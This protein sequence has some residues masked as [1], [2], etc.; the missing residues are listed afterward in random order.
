MRPYLIRRWLTDVVL[1]LFLRPLVAFGRAIEKGLGPRPA[2]WLLSPVLLIDFLRRLPD[3]NYFQRLRSQLPSSISQPP[4]W[5]HFWDMIRTWQETLAICLLYDRLGDPAWTQRITVVGIMPNQLPEWSHRPVVLASLHSGG[6]GLLRYWLRARNIPT[7][8][9]LAYLPIIVGPLAARI[10]TAGDIRY[11]LSNIPHTISIQ[12]A[13]REAIRFLVPGRALVVALDGGKKADLP[14]LCP[15][16]GAVFHLKDGA[17]RLAQRN[18]ALLIPVFVHRLAPFRFEVHFG[19]PVPDDLLAQK[20]SQPTMQ[21][22]ATAFWD[23]LRRDPYAFNW[24]VL[25]G[26]TPDKIEE[27]TPWP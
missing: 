15:V 26:L 11:R 21:Y 20:E 12:N 22:L 5:L 2:F 3:F 14:V 7:A 16:E 13:L 10:R 27:R 24:T 23:H 25:E 8:L 19:S 18:H 17:V 1:P 4:A 6:F 9:L